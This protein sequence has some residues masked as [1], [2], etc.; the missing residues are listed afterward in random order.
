[1]LFELVSILFSIVPDYGN[2]YLT[3][4]NNNWT[5]FKNF[6]PELNLNH[7]I[8]KGKPNH[9]NHTFAAC[10]T[11]VENTTAIHRTSH[12]H[13]QPMASSQRISVTF[14]KLCT[15]PVEL[16]WLLSN[17]V[18][19]VMHVHMLKFIVTARSFFPVL[20]SYC[21]V[22]GYYLRVSEMQ[23]CTWSFPLLSVTVDIVRCPFNKPLSFVYLLWLLQWLLSSCSQVSL[24]LICTV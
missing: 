9:F 12:V 2:E 17:L 11:W 23:A 3:K 7:N 15:K 18:G 21:I 4:E 5:S 14:M 20:I 6:A 8:H 13:F 1:M 16:L 24:G 19:A 10:L 22:Y